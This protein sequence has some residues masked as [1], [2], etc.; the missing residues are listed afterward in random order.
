MTLTLEQE[1]ELCLRVVVAALLAA[2]IGFEREHKDRPAGLRTHI[3][4]GVGSALFT[5]ISLYAFTGNEHARVAA[6]I[7]SGIG[8][9]G[10]GIIFQ[11]RTERTHGLTTAAGIWAVAAIGMACG[12]RLYVVAI[13]I[14]LLIVFVLHVLAVVEKRRPMNAKPKSREEVEDVIDATARD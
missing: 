12:S 8:F 7:V 11:D 5:V 3:L 4:V 13:V 2:V 14:T 10:A 6:Q 9:L 1:L